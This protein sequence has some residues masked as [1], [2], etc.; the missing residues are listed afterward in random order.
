MVV[1]DRQPEP[2]EQVHTAGLRVQDVVEKLDPPRTLLRRIEA[3]RLHFVKLRQV[4]IAPPSVGESD[5]SISTNRL[6][7]AA[8]A[9]P[10][11]A[12]LAS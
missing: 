4:D 5:E 9:R 7:D 10:L 2:G 1:I 12:A 6:I 3:L 11:P 8:M